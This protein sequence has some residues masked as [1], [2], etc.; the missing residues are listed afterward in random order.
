MESA[1]ALRL[2]QLNRA[3]YDA[4]AE[5][6][7]DSRPRLAPGVQRVLAGITPG[8]G[9]LEL[10]CGDGKVGRWLR[11]NVA[12]VT[13]VGLDIS[14]AM[15]ERARR[16]T[17]EEGGGRS[18]EQGGE[19][20][21]AGIT[22]ALADLAAPGWGRVLPGARFDWVV[23][24]AVLHHVPG[25]EAR[26]QVLGE[27]AAGLAPGGRL[28]MSN[29]QF[30]RSERLQRRV[31]PWA[32]LGLAEADVEPGDYLLGWE[33]RGQAGL[34]YVHL[35][36]EAEARALAGRAG[37]AVTEVFSA[38]GGSGALAEYVVLEKA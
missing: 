9:L 30:M 7:A 4:H 15:L 5:A 12:A 18:G 23:A 33:R 8:A 22:F 27:A 16:Y 6:F 29:W 11:R 1:T 21:A 32:A 36:D 3:F 38:D 35:L 25:F 31:A 14:E 28:A 17:E 37:L 20:K 34:R 26:A 13:Y 24:F 19:G 2:N 10:G